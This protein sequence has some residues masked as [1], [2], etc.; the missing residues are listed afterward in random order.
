MK[1]NKTYILVGGGSGGPVSPLLAV[2]EVLDKKMPE[3]KPVLFGS[4]NPEEGMAKKAK[5][6]Y[7]YVTSGKWRRY[8]S[9]KNLITPFELLIG[10]LQSLYLLP[11]LRPAFILGT[12]SYIQVPVMWAGWCLGIPVF[13]HQQDYIPSL[14]NKLCAPIAKEITV[15]FEKSKYD[16]AQSWHLDLGSETERIEFI[17][18]PTRRMKLHSRTVALKKLG[19][20]PKYPT[21]LVTG[22]GTGAL[23]LNSLVWGSLHAL[24]NIANVIHLTGRGKAAPIEAER[25][26]QMEFTDD[27]ETMYSAADLVLCRAGLGTL[28]ELSELGK[29]AIVVPIPNG[30]QEYNAAYAGER[31]AVLVLDEELLDHNNLVT[32]VR[33]VFFDHKLQTTLAKNISKL[34]PQSADVALAE[35]IGHNIHKPKRVGK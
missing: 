12:G 22:G 34:F 33:S 9:L 35:I 24:T 32:V 23:G 3:L 16:F 10:F 19:L 26:L 20:D 4:G 5:V 27:M 21:L 13:L 6:K 31:E 8:F 7:Y 18:N 14:A 2:K 1:K 30:Q 25:Y 11:G 15:S 28:S 17:G 29:P